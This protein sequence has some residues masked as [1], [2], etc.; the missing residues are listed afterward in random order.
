MS[1]LT[2]VAEEEYSQPSANV[3]ITAGDLGGSE[4]GMTAVTSGAG[5]LDRVATAVRFSSIERY[6][7]ALVAVGSVSCPCRLVPAA[8]EVVGDLSERQWK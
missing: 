2:S 6:S 5:D 7:A 3:D 4:E 1:W 8:F